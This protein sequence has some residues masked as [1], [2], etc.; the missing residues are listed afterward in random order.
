MKKVVSN[1]NLVE[2]TFRATELIEEFFDV[3]DYETSSSLIRMEM[4]VIEFPIFSKNPKIKKNQIL[5]YYFS[6]DKKSFLE[7]VPPVNESIPNEFDER[8]FISLLKIMKQKGSYKTFY[9]SITDIADN[10]NVSNSTKKGMYSKIKNSVLKLSKTSYSFFNLFYLGPLNKKVDDLITTPL[11][12]SRIL[13]LNDADNQ[14]KDMFRDKRTKELYKINIADDIYNNIT[15]KGYLVFDSDVLLNIKDPVVRSLYTQIT[16]WRFN[17]LYLKKPVS[18]IAQKIPLSWKGTMKFKSVKK[19]N[20]SLN[21]LKEMS[22]ITDYN[23]IKIN[24]I[25]NG[26]FEIFFSNEHNKVKQKLFYQDKI[27]YNNL[28]HS[29]EERENT[30]Y[31]ESEIDKN[32][33]EIIKIFEAKGFGLKTLPS[34]LKDALKQYDFEYVR[35][36]S[37]YTVINAK[38]NI[39]K[40]FKDALINNW[41]EEYI[42]KKKTKKLK[43]DRKL[44]IEEAI[45]IAKEEERKVF[46]W[47]EFEKLSIES[48]NKLTEIAYSNFLVETGS[49]D[50]NIQKKIFKKAE[51]TY[52]TALYDEFLKI[53]EEEHKQH[54]ISEK[55]K[56]F[57]LEE[58]LERKV[59]KTSID[60]K[61]EYKNVELK[62]YSGIAKFTMEL[63]LLVKKKTLEISLEDIASSLSFFKE[64]EDDY[65]YAVY[66]TETNFG[67]YNE[68]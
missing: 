61:R 47:D 40:Y 21:I 29:V 37:E 35:Y 46:S 20:D 30:N 59:E 51:K 26:E 4:N 66:N 36:T 9:C 24:K 31:S 14:E 68:K 32:I 39:I 57:G 11:I 53:K 42:L 1:E 23:F 43:K 65:Y 34:I 38:I 49:N 22:L 15:D 10:L 13:T 18:Y 6:K 19:I 28:I 17:S 48:Q 58:T 64:Y 5:K 44:E 56:M 54:E 33:I 60:S 25:E 27:D 52:I 3:L 41:A 55:I 7:I 63:Y 45:I 16:K 50:D 12:T 8:V 62:E 67:G 2:T